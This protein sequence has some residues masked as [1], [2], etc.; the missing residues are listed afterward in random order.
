METTLFSYEEYD[1]LDTLVLQY[2]SCILKVDIG[3][4]KVGDE[5]D[6]I[7]INYD[8]GKITLGLDTV[9]FTYNLS[10]NINNESERIQ[11]Y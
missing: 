7:T 2:Y 6:Y 10:L 8:E 9:E 11:E 5:I 1:I 4:F 3:R